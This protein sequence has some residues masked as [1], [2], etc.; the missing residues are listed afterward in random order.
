MFFMNTSYLLKY[1]TYVLFS[2]V[3]NYKNIFGDHLLTIHVKIIKRYKKAI[4]LCRHFIIKIFLF[5]VEE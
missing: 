3:S 1:L 5:Y 4:L 2:E